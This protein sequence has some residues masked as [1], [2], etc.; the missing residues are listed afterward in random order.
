MPIDC[1]QHEFV[2]PKRAVLGP[3]DVKKWEQSCAYQDLLGFITSMNMAV[4]GKKTSAPCLASP[5]TTNLLKMLD[6]IS[7]W[8]DDIA[9]I[10][11]PQRY[12]NKA[13]RDFYSRLK[14]QGEKI[15]KEALPEEFHPAVPEVGIY[16]MESFGNSTRIDYGTGHELSFIMCLG[17]IFKIG[18]LKQE[19]STAV[20]TQIFSRYIALCR[21]LQI[22]YKMEPA[23]SQ[24]VWSLDDYQFIP[25]IWGSS[26]LQMNP[27]ISPEM[28]CLEKIANDHA[29]EYLFLNC[30]KFIL[31]VLHKFPIV[32]HVLFGSILT[33]TPATEMVYHPPGTDMPPISS[34]NTVPSFLNSKPLHGNLFLNDNVPS[35][36]PHYGRIPQDLPLNES[37]SSL[38]HVSTMS[39]GAALTDSD[40]SD[41][42]SGATRST[43]LSCAE[44]RHP[45][46]SP[47]N[48]L[49]AGS[50]PKCNLTTESSNESTK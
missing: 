20:V 4:K 14:E 41:V 17:C 50:F 38:P 44:G 39:Q 46:M 10:D 8:V 29:D 42:S 31:S 36:V 21:K 1:G 15:L 24:G 16:L 49:T 5:V 30:I 7:Q 13:F 28:F 35:N 27:K 19:D 2:E 6:T 3:A 25:F 47:L 33:M 40:A 37:Q 32:Q 12:G 9:P 11:Q 43:H 23:G 18:A 34:K 45:A 26:Q 22:I 48:P